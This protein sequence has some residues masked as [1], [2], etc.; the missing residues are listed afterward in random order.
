MK[1]DQSL[2]RLHNANWWKLTYYKKGNNDSRRIWCEK[3][4]VVT[5]WCNVPPWIFSVLDVDLHHTEQ[6]RKW[7]QKRKMVWVYVKRNYFN[8]IQI[9]TWDDQGMDIWTYT[10]ESDGYIGKK[11]WRRAV[12]SN[13]FWFVTDRRG[14]RGLDPRAISRHWDHHIPL[15]MFFLE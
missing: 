9:F 8:T 10:T 15:R 1:Q 12:S 2:T 7:I 6:K 14:P 3:V 4:R 13:N 11:N 5:V